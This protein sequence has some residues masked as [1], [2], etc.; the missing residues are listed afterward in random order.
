MPTRLQ[1]REKGCNVNRSKNC[2]KHCLQNQHF[3][4]KG[5]GGAFFGP[6]L[7]GARLCRRGAARPAAAEV[8]AGT[9]APGAPSPKAPG[10]LYASGPRT[11]GLHPRHLM[12]PRGRTPPNTPPPPRAAVREVLPAGTSLPGQRLAPE[13][14]WLKWP[15]IGQ[16]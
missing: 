2:K 5:R 13:H 12:K 16:K 4:L 8:H 14:L 15:K 3:S 10:A 1:C 11:I 6:P 7:C 9:T